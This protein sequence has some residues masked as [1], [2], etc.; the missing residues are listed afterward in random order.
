MT[1]DPTEKSDTG[2]ELLCNTWKC[3][4]FTEI[5]PDDFPWQVLTCYEHAALG[6]PPTPLAQFPLLGM[7]GLMTSKESFN[8]KTLGI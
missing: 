6:K 7:K 3:S 4:H 1:P 2:T 8:L 5:I